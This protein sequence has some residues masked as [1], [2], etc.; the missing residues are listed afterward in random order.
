MRRSFALEPLSV[1]C[2]VQVP[3]GIAGAKGAPPR[4]ARNVERRLTL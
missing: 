1:W 2:V 3:Y 4:D